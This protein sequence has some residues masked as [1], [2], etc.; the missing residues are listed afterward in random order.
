MNVTEDTHARVPLA[1]VRRALGALTPLGWRHLALQVGIFEALG[2]LYALTGVYGRR[3]VSAA[4]SN[5][6]AIL[7]TEQNLGL[8]FEAPLQGWVLQGPHVLQVVA[9][10][11][12]FSCQFA[13]STAFLLWVYARRTT[14]FGAVRDA[15]VAA[16]LVALAV[17]IAFPAAP[18]R[19]VRG[20]GIVDTLET[21]SVNMHSGLIDALNNAYSAMPSLHASYALVLGVAGVALTRR[22]WVRAIWALYPGLVFYSI[23]ATGNHFVLDAVAGVAALAAT[24]LVGRGSRALER[25]CSHSVMEQAPRVAARQGGAR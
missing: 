25:R 20:S 16:N 24:P 22:R 17:A 23:I 9:N 4:I 18:P 13:V 19:L 10:E 2:G 7:D 6:K 21:D 11:T 5:S 12:Y 15:L 8:A 14:Y 3:E 1:A